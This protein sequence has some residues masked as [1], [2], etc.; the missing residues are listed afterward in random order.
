MVEVPVMRLVNP[1][2]VATVMP[3]VERM[4]AVEMAPVRTVEV[5]D[6][7]ETMLPPVI[8]RP[9][10]EETPFAATPPLMVEVAVDE[11]MLRTPAMVV[12]ALSESMKKRGLAEVDVAMEKA[13]LVL[14]GI[15]EVADR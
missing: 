8:L 4:P 9:F 13:Y 6:T 5:P 11:A 1:P 14:A 10:D 2:A 12:E 7:V 15:V 3:L